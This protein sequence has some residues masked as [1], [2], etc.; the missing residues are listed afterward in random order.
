MEW[1]PRII[2]KNSMQN[3]HEG[4]ARNHVIVDQV[5]KKKKIYPKCPHDKT[6]E[7]CKHCSPHLFCQ[8]KRVKRSC[9]DCGGSSLC[10]HQR[11]RS[12]CKDCGGSGLCEHQRRRSTCKECGGGS[13][14]EHQRRRSTCKDCGGS[15]VC[16]HQRLRSQCKDC[17][18]SS[19][20]EHQRQRST[21]KDCGG[22]GL[23]EHQRI[24]SR[25][26][27]CLKCHIGMCENR[28]AKSI[29]RTS[30]Y[31][32]Q[33][34]IGSQ[35]PTTGTEIQNDLLVSA[36]L[37]KVNFNNAELDGFQ[38]DF[39]FDTYIKVGEK[40]YTPAGMCSTC[41]RE[42]Q[43]SRFRVGERTLHCS[44]RW[45]E[46]TVASEKLCRAV[47]MYADLCFR[48]SYSGDNIEAAASSSE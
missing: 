46:A 42:E 3:S 15:S 40:Y 30:A 4:D 45:C 47:G 44:Q 28:V 2:N 21:C 11:Q 8:H 39:F 25:C 43:R 34:I 7:N 9:K 14:C 20:C 41:S 24:R 23:C 13:L 36:L 33:E 32:W 31:K 26:T 27:K 35:Q 12:T 17:S 37:Q 10:E 16:E 19:L 48:R 29:A 6:K 38:Q 5:F 1:F 18:G 22:G